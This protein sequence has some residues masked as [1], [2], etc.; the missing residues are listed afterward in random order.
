[1]KVTVKNMKSVFQQMSNKEKKRAEA[2]LNA[3]E[4]AEEEAGQ[5]DREAP[6]I[7][8]Q[9]DPNVVEVEGLEQAVIVDG[10]EDDEVDDLV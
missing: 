8:D 7:S 6:A 2:A 5:A 10:Y 4:A 1:M 3:E 9:V